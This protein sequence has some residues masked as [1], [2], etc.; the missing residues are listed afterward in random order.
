MGEC[1][2]SVKNPKN[3]IKY[4]VNFVVS[5]NDLMSILGL[6]ASIYINL[7]KVQDS[8]FEMVNN[9][10]EEYAGVFDENKQGL[11]KG[12]VNLKLEYGSKPVIMANRKCPVSL[13]QPLKDE[14]DR[15]I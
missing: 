1:R 15:L 5:D 11:I 10:C 8:N 7:I 2:L 13:H 9:V 3:G 12:D 6:K 14:L 4:N